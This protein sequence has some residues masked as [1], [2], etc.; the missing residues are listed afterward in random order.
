MVRVSGRVV[1]FSLTYNVSVSF[2]SG[3]SD[4]LMVF[5]FFLTLSVSGIRRALTYGSDNPLGSIG[6]RFF[7]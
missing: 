5:V 4:A 1:L 2:H 3:F 7:P 6:I